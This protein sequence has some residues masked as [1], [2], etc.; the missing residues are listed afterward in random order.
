MQCLWGR[1]VG[2]FDRDLKE[3]KVYFGTW[4]SEFYGYAPQGHGWSVFKSKANKLNLYPFIDSFVVGR[5]FTCMG[6]TLGATLL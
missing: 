4:D 6:I 5:C 1:I 3:D 2:P